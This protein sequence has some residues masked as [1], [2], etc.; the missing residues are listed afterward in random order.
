MK[1]QSRSGG[2]RPVKVVASLT[3][4]ERT[5]GPE[6][7]SPDPIASCEA[8]V[9]GDIEGSA[10]GQAT[11]HPPLEQRC[12]RTHVQLSSA[13]PLARQHPILCRSCIFGQIFK[14]ATPAAD[15]G[16]VSP[17][18]LQRMRMHS[19]FGTPSRHREWTA[20]IRV[21]T[22][23]ALYEQQSVTEQCDRLS[24]GPQR[25]FSGVVPNLRISM[26]SGSDA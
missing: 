14:T 15:H 18:P 13:R 16:R 22:F 26:R 21:L 12:G 3:V 1:V 23:H 6:E 10:F 25:Q 8:P 24:G 7:R 11:R 20:R 19:M 9:S 2:A 5:P 4:L 17:T